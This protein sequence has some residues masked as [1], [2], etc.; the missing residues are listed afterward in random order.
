M[1]PSGLT[2]SAWVQA[3][4]GANAAGAWLIHLTSRTGEGGMAIWNAGSWG[5][6]F[7]L[8]GYPSG[9]YAN[10][11]TAIPSAW[12]HLVAVYKQGQFVEYWV[13][14]SLAQ[15]NTVPNAPLYTDPYFPLNSSIGNYDYA[16]G[17]YNGFTGAMDDVRIY[18][19]ALAPGEVQA[20]YQGEAAS[21]DY[22]MITQQ[23]QSQSVQAGSTAIFTATAT[24]SPPLSYQWWFEWDQPC[25]GDR[26]LAHAEQCATRPGGP[27][28]SGG[29]QRRGFGHQL[30]R[31]ADG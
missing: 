22:P 8:V 5:A 16:P 26:R 14:G 6:W 13:N 30:E 24:G 17:P 20:L 3:D 2:V 9:Y 31:N 12:T 27:L 10:Q 21:P 1:Q 4:S 18:N 29:D 15:S 11:D 23:P 19:R 25:R 7:K 28:L